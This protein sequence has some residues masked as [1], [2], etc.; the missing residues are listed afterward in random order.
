VR[1]ALLAVTVELSDGHRVFGSRTDTQRC[2][3]FSSEVKFNL[4]QLRLNFSNVRWVR[5]SD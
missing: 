2:A 5:V 4:R 1:L 3:V